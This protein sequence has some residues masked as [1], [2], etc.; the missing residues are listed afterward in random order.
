MHNRIEPFGWEVKDEK[1]K[2]HGQCVIGFELGYTVSVVQNIAIRTGGASA[3][4]V[5]W[6]DTFLRGNPY[7]WTRRYDRQMKQEG[8]RQIA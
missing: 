5:A 7:W 1:S 6:E 3:R 4:D 8:T 2:S